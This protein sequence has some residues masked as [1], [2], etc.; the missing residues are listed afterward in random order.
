MKI[1]K[2]YGF[3]TAFAGAVVILIN[4]LGDLFGFKIESKLVENVIMA[5]AGVL[6][7]LGVVSMS[8]TKKEDAQEAE[9]EV[10]CEED[11]KATETEQQKT[12]E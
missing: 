10:E 8:G 1:F 5:V 12:E 7:A 6:V 4:A 11:A 2:T 9:A 3:W